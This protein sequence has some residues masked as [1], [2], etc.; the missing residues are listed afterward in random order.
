MPLA[1]YDVCMEL[2]HLRYFIA[3]VQAGSLTAAA[4][5]LHMSQP[6]LSVAITQLEAELGVQ[7]LTRTSKG[8]D[9]TSA[10]RYL[11]DASSRIL[12]DIDQL[13]STLGRF[14]S[15]A[16]GALTVAAVPQLMWH[17]IPR[18]LRDFAE[19]SPEVEVRLTD[20]PPW[21]AL[22]MLSQARTD[23][24]AIVVSDAQ[25]FV[26]RHEQNYRITDWGPVPMVAVLPPGQAQAA[27]PL[28]LEEFHDQLV[29]VPQ[30]TS[31]VPSV[32]EAVETTFQQYGIVPREIRTTQT[33]AT[34]L[35]LIEAGL[36]RAILPD[37]DGVSLAA[38][39]DVT[40]R[41]LAPEP[42]PL[43][44]LVLS[45]VDQHNPVLERFLHVLVEATGTPV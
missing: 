38:R 9:P 25:R 29:L 28:A 35:P 45:R 31:A 11:L 10:G 41:R 8:V 40:V 20:P 36:A 26:E 39:F 13:V 19:V 14:G 12:G 22:D 2:R 6:P 17:R 7:L 30:R 42:Q 18:L 44:A 34:A 15:G 21:T 5:D 33:I 24:A 23:V 27:Q 32:P 43:R 1:D 4:A 3:V 37:P 16:A